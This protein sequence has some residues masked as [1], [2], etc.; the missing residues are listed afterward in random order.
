[1]IRIAPNELSFI[2]EDAFQG[3]YCGGNGNKGFQKYD[4]YRLAGD[5]T[6]IF[7]ADDDEHTR[8]RNIIKNRFF[9]LR[10][11]REQEVI[12]QGYVDRLIAQLRAHHC[13]SRA[14][15]GNMPIDSKKPADIRS[16]YNWTTLDILGRIAFTEDF[17]CLENGAPHPWLVML[18]PYLK[19]STLAMSLLYYPP[20][21]LIVSKLAPGMLSNLQEKFL[22][23]LR[24]KITRRINRV[25]PP[26]KEDFVTIA[27]GEHT[28]EHHD[29]DKDDSDKRSLMLTPSQL[30]A[31]SLFLC[32]AGSETVASVLLGAT[33]LLCENPEI[34][35]RLT[36]EVRSAAANESDISSHHAAMSMPYLTAVLR[37]SMRMCPPLTFKPSRVVGK[38]GAV[39]AGHFVPPEVSFE[40]YSSAY[41]HML[42][43]IRLSLV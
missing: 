30:E 31:H 29:G 42:T 35:K 13:N 11:V 6:S 39:I 20:L 19:L 21:P 25:L 28:E 34:L 32:I 37:E 16:W 27:V 9:S 5:F 2:D 36:T 12:V 10:V 41:I 24:D 8:L 3:I 38:D 43:I 1:M 7:D 26:G 22:F 4:V 33:H 40:F 17:G 14:T 18:E 23:H 15:Q